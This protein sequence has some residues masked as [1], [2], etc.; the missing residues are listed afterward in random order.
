MFWQNEAKLFKYF[1]DRAQ[2]HEPLR[3]P[4]RLQIAFLQI[5]SWLTVDLTIIAL[6]VIVLAIGLWM[7]F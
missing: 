4:Y 7:G 3:G 5:Q 6:S 1:N 2:A